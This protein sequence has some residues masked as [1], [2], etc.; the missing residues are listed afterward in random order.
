VDRSGD[1]VFADPA[2]ATDQDR[3]VGVGNALDDRPDRSHPRVAV[4]E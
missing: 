2:F 3:G 4:E 1:E